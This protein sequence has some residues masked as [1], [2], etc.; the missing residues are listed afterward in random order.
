[1]DAAYEF[2]ASNEQ[3]FVGKRHVNNKALRRKE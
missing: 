3:F 1:V 2:A